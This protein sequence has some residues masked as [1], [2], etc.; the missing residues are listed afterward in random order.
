[1]LLLLFMSKKTRNKN[2]FIFL[3][4]IHHIVLAL[5]MAGFVGQTHLRAKQPM[6]LALVLSLASIPTVGICVCHVLITRETKC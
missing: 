6:H 4:Q 2:L 3:L 1:M 5:G